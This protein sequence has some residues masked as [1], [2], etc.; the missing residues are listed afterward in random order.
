MTPPA[1]RP[2]ARR[3]G[4]GPRARL[5]TRVLLVLVLL[6]GGLAAAGCS[7]DGGGSG[8]G[9]G[10]G[11]G[12][13][14]GS[15]AGPVR[16]TPGHRAGGGAG[17]GGGGGGGRTAERAH[18]PTYVALGDSYTAAPFVPQTVLGNSCLRSSNNY[19]TLVAARL[20]GTHLVDV[21]CSGADTGSMVRVQRTGNGNEPPQF[22]ALTRGTD[23]VTVGIG[24]NDFNLFG[25]LVGT[26][27]QLRASDPTGSPCRDRFTAGGVDQLGNE[28]SQVRARVAAVVAGIRQRAP[29]A[30]VVVVGYPQI[31]PA[32]GTCPRRLPLA[33]GDYPFARR[34]N[35]GLAA[36]VNAG[37]R[38]ADA[39]VNVFRHSAGHDICSAHPWIN[40]SLTDTSRALAY[41][42]FAAE[43][44][45]V[46]RLV[47]AAL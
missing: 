43:Q 47:L 45:A 37:A 31:I 26:C 20:P 21:S 22:D 27:T 34:M 17:A 25:T 10:R 15:G 23:L 11:A 6:G 3:T 30:R 33:T 12:S 5:L 19:P 8:S 35:A 39:Y 28:L 14:A 9:S 42:P 24:G 38:R 36:A 16:T 46:A 4:G 32:H 29:H 7:N 41:H 40:G 13:G 44:A 1:H 18:Y 2:P